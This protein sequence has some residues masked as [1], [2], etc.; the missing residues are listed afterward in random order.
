MEKELKPYMMSLFEYL[1]YAAGSEL[2]KEVYDTANKLRETIRTQEVSNPKY[3]GKVM[4]Y[5]REFLDLYFGNM[6]YEGDKK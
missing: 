6:V 3:S 5:R 2:G 1:G 4:L